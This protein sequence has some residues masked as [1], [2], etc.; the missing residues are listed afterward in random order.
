MAKG[1]RSRGQIIAG[2]IPLLASLGGFCEGVVGIVAYAAKDTA[3]FPYVAM[4]S[5]LLPVFLA[6]MI[7]RLITRHHGNLYSPGD[8]ANAEDFI[9]IVKMTAGSVRQIGRTATGN[10]F[11]PLRDHTIDVQQAIPINNQ[12][13]TIEKVLNANAPSD[14]LILHSWFNA[15]QRHDLAL[16]CIDLAIAKGAN[17]SKNFSFRSATLRKLGRIKEAMSSAALALDLSPNHPDALYNLACIHLQIG[18]RDKAVEIYEIL[19]QAGESGYATR[20]MSRLE[21]KSK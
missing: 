7:Y 1:P 12:V 13:I 19:S 18:G 2:P 17:E 14:Y 21:R 5:L 11:E 4:G 20:L 3:I 16:M 6:S 8:F 9:K 10:I 15:E